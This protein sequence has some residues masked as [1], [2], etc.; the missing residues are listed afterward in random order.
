MTVEIIAL[1]VLV[2]VFAISAIRNVHMGALA[3]VAAVLVGVLLVGEPLDDVLGGFPVDA[4]LILLG[5]TYLFG[6]ARTVGAVDWLVDRSVRLI[7][8]R[9]ALIPWA[10]LVVGTLVACLGTSHA[11]FT[12]VPIAM[13]LAHKHRIH[14]TMMGIVMSS[15]IVGGALA[16]TSIVG[17]TVMTVAN[18]AEIPYNAGLMF[19]LSIG[20]N[21]L[22]VL[23]AFF[24]F[25]GRELIARGRA[26]KAART[27]GGAASLGGVGGGSGVTGVLPQTATQKLTGYQLLTLISIP[28]L[29][30]AFFTLTINDVD[31]NLGAVALTIAVL[32]AF[33]NPKVG[34]EALGKVDWGTILLL[35]GI[36]TYVGVLTRLGAIDQLGEAARSVSVPIIAAVVLC[37]I[38]ALVSAF[39]ST[40]GIIGALVPLAVPLLVP[41]GGLEMTGFIYAL[42]ISASL[43]DCAPFGTT[44]ATIVAS[45]PEEDRPRLYRHLMIWGLSMVVIGPV[46]TIL[47][48]VVPFLGA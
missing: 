46:I 10:M 32:L 11:A 42:A 47:L 9:V 39:A 40:I 37:V 24:M 45:G 48:F 12:I 34:R 7:G 28:V 25:G 22:V 16:P 13:S 38:A 3:L 35:G 23:V 15:A 27:S 43:V 17:I 31:L 29:V 36:I 33:I 44:G 14:T 6:I 4:L 19:A 1:V 26:A 21:A 41:G 5:I 30:I 8:D 18:A 2:A 20:V